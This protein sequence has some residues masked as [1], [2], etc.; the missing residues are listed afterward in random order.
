M[1][2]TE[3]TEFSEFRL[4]LRTLRY[5]AT[6]P[7]DE[8]EKNTQPNYLVA[9][10]NVQYRLFTLAKGK[11]CA[12]NLIWKIFSSFAHMAFA[13]QSKR[14]WF[15]RLMIHRATVEMHA[16]CNLCIKFSLAALDVKH[17]IKATF[18]ICCCCCRIRRTF[19]LQLVYMRNFFSPSLSVH[20]NCYRRKW[21]RDY[22]YPNCVISL[23]LC[24]LYVCKSVHDK[25][26][27]ISLLDTGTVCIVCYLTFYVFGLV[28]NWRQQMPFSFSFHG[29]SD[30]HTLSAVVVAAAFFSAT[31]WY[32]KKEQIA[33]V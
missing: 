18:R 5:M 15:Y 17:K 28:A 13:L 32:N 7:A 24:K 4:H 23:W 27:C 25:A 16:K 2:F 10:L 30:I 21:V 31:T 8:N 20:L 11:N 3:E 19:F 14:K 26:Q 33:V 1:I 12:L 29:F 9:T 6:V 22:L